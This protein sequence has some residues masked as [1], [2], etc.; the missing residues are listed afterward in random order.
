MYTANMLVM[1]VDKKKLGDRK[2]PQKWDDILQPE[3]ENNIIMRGENDSFVMQLC[4]LFI[5]IMF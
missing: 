3:F 2:M 5:K 1:V 4:Y